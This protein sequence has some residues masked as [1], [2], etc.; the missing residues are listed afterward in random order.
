MPRLNSQPSLVN[1]VRLFVAAY[2][3]PSALAWLIRKYSRIQGDLRALKR[4]KH[5]VPG[6]VEMLEA[7]AESLRAVLAMHD[8]TVNPADI[9]AIQTRPRKTTFAFGKLT[10]GILTCL[11]LAK[12]KPRTT[13][14]VA[15]FVMEY[16]GYNPP[17]QELGPFKRRVRYRLLG[18]CKQKKVR[19]AHVELE[20]SE[21]GSWLL[22]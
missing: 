20:T 5:A 1:P 12:G 8:E 2:R 11:R 19:R 22:A 13:S 10:R 16:T 17:A 3:T 4:A 15:E 18:L 21:E 9:P 7:E 6:R 14:E